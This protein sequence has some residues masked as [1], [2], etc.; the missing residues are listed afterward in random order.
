MFIAD[1]DTSG[2]PYVAAKYIREQVEPPGGHESVGRWIEALR[3]TVANS[4]AKGLADDAIFGLVLSEA[5]KASADLDR[6]DALRDEFLAANAA[7]LEALLYRPTL[8]IVG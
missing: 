8:R 4:R 7:V 3:S 1:I 5:V 6:N 2:F